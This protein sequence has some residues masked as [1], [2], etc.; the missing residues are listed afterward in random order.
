MHGILADAS[1]IYGIAGR[2]EIARQPGQT[3]WCNDGE[4][5]LR[6]KIYKLAAF[7]TQARATMDKTTTGRFAPGLLAPATLGRTKSMLPSSFCLSANAE[8]GIEI[9]PYSQDLDRS[10]GSSAVV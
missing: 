5:N 9:A 8:A 10:C 2:F 1:L 4:T 7:T 3:R 6:N